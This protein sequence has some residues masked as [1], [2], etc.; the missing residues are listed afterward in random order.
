MV[1]SRYFPEKE[2]KNTCIRINLFYIKDGVMQSHYISRGEVS[3]EEQDTIEY[4][5]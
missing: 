4:V 3:L 2:Q 1:K 5:S